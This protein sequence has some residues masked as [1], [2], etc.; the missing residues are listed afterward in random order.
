MNFEIW[1]QSN[2]CIY[3][4]ERA[5]GKPKTAERIA[6]SLRERPTENFSNE[7]ECQREPAESQRKVRSIDGAGGANSY[8]AEGTSDGKLSN[9]EG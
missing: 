2:N 5:N 4:A 7:K 6:I 8:F 9:E 1:L 3:S